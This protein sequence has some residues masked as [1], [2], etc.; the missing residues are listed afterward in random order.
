MDANTPL[1]LLNY[2]IQV[3]LGMLYLS[4]KGFVHRDLAAR[5]VLISDKD[6]CKV[7]SCQVETI[8]KT[9]ITPSYFCNRRLGTLACRVSW[10]TQSTIV[11][12]EE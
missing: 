5:N 7:Y 6:I 8:A 10:K 12:L 3:T 11:Q 9:P 1:V 4:E 2:S